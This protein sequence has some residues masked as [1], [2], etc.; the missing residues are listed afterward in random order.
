LVP[1]SP[2]DASDEILVE[3]ARTGN[4]RAL[5]ALL[6]RHQG[7]VLRVL[8]FLGVAAQDREDVAQEVFIRVVRH[9][10][11]FRPGRPFGAWLYRV[12]VN[13]AHDWRLR[14]ERNDRSAS[15]WTEDLDAPDQGPGPGEA[16]ASGELRRALDAA[17]GLLS[18]RERAVFVLR[19][20]EGLETREVARTLGITTIT[21]RRHLALARR[22]LKRALE[23]DCA[24]SA[25]AIERIAPGGGS[26]G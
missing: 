10:P 20:I 23:G 21:V 24:P 8:G 13:A 3:A 4:V 25:V 6:D 2:A 11:S 18:T 9:L 12:A 7:K 14:R 5:D 26:H 1:P 17:L 16:L 15:P 22:R 19:E